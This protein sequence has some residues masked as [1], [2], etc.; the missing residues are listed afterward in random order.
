[1]QVVDYGW[2]QVR[3][4]KRMNQVGESWQVELFGDAHAL[5]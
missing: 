1:M 5:N 3:L 2:G 4:R